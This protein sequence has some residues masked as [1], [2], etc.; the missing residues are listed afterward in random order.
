MTRSP[1][2]CFFNVA[3]Y[4]LR[5][6]PWIIVALASIVMFPTLEDIRVAFPNVDPRLLGHD[7][8]YP[9]MLK[10][11]P[12]GFLG[13]MVAGMLAAYV[14]T[15]VTHLN[16]GASYLVHDFW[17]QFVRPGE[18]ERHYVMMG[19]IMTVSLMAIAGALTFVLETAQQSFQ[20]LLSIGAGTGLLYLLRW[21]WWRINAWCEIAAM[22]ASFTAALGF[23]IAQKQ[24]VVMPSHVPL[25]ATVAITTLAWVVTALVT[26]PTDRET[27]VSFYRLVR[28]AGPGWTACGPRPA[29]RPHRI[30]CRRRSSR[31]CWVASPCMA[32]CSAP[33]HTSTGTTGRRSSGEW[34]S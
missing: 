22:V 3:H 17:R 12:H 25:L 15:I 7:M 34:C 20:L 32:P 1:A 27:L 6:W 5:S 31:G 4:A 26:A 8:A 9:A 11:L 29:C 18:D 2:R 13:L 16:W 24:G 10:F 19:R 30:R 14:S 23:F 21:F 28:P 33:A